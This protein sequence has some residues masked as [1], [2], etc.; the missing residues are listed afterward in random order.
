V[1]NE[2]TKEDDWKYVGNYWEQDFKDVP[3]IF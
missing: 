3:D 2:H 1:K